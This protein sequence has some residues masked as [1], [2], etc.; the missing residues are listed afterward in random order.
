ML[1]KSF[2]NPR[3]KYIRKLAQ[4]KF[5]EKERKFIVE[6]S[7]MVEEALSSK[8]PLEILVYTNEWSFSR[9]GRK[10]LQQAEE[11][12]LKK[13][14]V[15]KIVFNRLATAETPQGVLAVA[16][17]KENDLVNLLRN[18]LSLLLLVDAIQDPGNLG[19]IIRSADAAA[20]QAV[21]FTRGTVELYNPK[22]LRATM[23]SLFHLPVLAVLEVDSLLEQLTACGWQLVVGDPKAEII[24]SRHNFTRP[25]VLA[26]GNES[27][28][29]SEKILKRAN[30]I[31]SIPMPGRAESLNVAAAAAIMLYEVVRQRSL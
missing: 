14:E 8:W 10:I 21:L 27:R 20:V 30:Q 17:Q 31:V 23:G 4:Q 25:T 2:Q 19:A 11:I 7:L 18:N 28:G 29:C 3:L 12:N 9:A 5:R 24:L 13:L 16:H 6:G 26:V 15:E 22:T 1:V